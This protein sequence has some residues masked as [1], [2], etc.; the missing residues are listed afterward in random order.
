MK[1]ADRAE[2]RMKR[3]TRTERVRRY[4]T[5]LNEVTEVLG[6]TEKALD[7]Y[8]A[9]RPKIEALKE[10]YASAA[11]KRDFSASEKG[12]LPADLPS[13]VLSEDGINDVL[14]EDLALLERIGKIA[15][16]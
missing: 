8:E 14:D 9:V 11:W 16:L 15:R 13:G 3:E 1:G 5:M 7:A 12:L 6:I 4:E 10:Y 2:A